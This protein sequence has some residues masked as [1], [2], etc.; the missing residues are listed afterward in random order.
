MARP[1]TYPPSRARAL[2]A[3]PAIAEK[4]ERYESTTFTVPAGANFVE[5]FRFSGRPD[6]IRLVVDTSA[7]EV[8]FRIRGRAAGTVARV[9]P[10]AAQQTWP[11]AEIVETRDPL[12]GGN[13]SLTIIGFWAEHG[14]RG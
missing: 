14:G 4:Y 3:Q 13:Q 5:A 6:T 2:G 12:G 8:R 9:L 11:S 10:N 7:L 1:A